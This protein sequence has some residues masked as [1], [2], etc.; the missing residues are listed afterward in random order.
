M[1]VGRG[2]GQPEV[3]TEGSRLRGKCKGLFRTAEE[4]EVGGDLS[5]GGRCVS[6]CR[7]DFSSSQESEKEKVMLDRSQR[8]FSV[9]Q[10]DQHH[11]LKVGLHG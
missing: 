1:A 4:G 9:K 10:T 6:G 5:T 7:M 11:L 8:I 2:K 3:K